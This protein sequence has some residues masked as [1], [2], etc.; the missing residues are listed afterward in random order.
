[1]N[2][3][4]RDIE[5]DLDTFLPYADQR[6]IAAVFLIDTERTSEGDARVQALA[7][8]LIDAALARGGRY[9]LPYRLYA[10]REQ[11]E[12]A[13]PKARA[14]FEA[15]HRYDPDALFQNRFSLQ[16]APL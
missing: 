16:Y 9:Y 3:T 12:R 15:K 14:F 2:V 10:T 8:E 6:M 7:R 1:M 13:Y 5:P 11:F 4:L